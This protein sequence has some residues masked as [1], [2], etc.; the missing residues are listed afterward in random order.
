MA[1]NVQPGEYS[2]EVSTSH[3]AMA[4]K[5][6][7]KRI[8]IGRVAALHKDY[9]SKTTFRGQH[10]AA[11]SLTQRQ[12]HPTFKVLASSHSFILEM[13]SII[14]AL[15]LSG[16]T[17]A[18]SESSSVW[19]GYGIY[20]PSTTLATATSLSTWSSQSFFSTATTSPPASSTLQT[21]VASTSSAAAGSAGAVSL[22]SYIVQY[23]SS[24]SDSDIGSAKV[25]LRSLVDSSARAAGAD[26]QNPS[27]VTH[28]FNNIIQGFSGK[29]SSHVVEQLKGHPAFQ[30][31]EKDPVVNI[32]VPFNK[33][34][35][36][37]RA[38]SF[39]ATSVHFSSDASASFSALPDSAEISSTFTF[40]GMSYLGCI[41]NDVANNQNAFRFYVG[42]G[43][44][45]PVTFENCI[46]EC[47]ARGYQ[48]AGAGDRCYCD[49][50]LLRM[51]SSDQCDTRCA[52]NPTELC[53]NS[54]AARLFGPSGG[55]TSAP[56]AAP[57]SMQPTATSSQAPAK[58]SSGSGSG[59]SAISWNG[60]SWGVVRI[61]GTQFSSSDYG[62]T[63]ASIVAHVETCAK[64][65]A[66][67][68]VYVLDTGVLTTHEDFG[69]RASWGANFADNTDADLNG[70]GTHVASGAIGYAA[71]MGKK[72]NVIAVKILGAD[73]SG[74]G[75]SVLQG[76]EWVLQQQTSNPKPCI[77]NMSLGTSGVSS[78]INQAVEN[79]VAA[80]VTV[81]VAAG[82]EAGDACQ[83]SPASASG[84]IT[85]GA[86]GNTAS[87][88]FN[89]DEIAQYSNFGS[90]VDVF[91]PGTLLRAAIN[92]GN[93]DYGEM[94]G[95]SMASPKTA[96][97]AAYLLGQ[98]P[99][100]NPS[101]L[102]AKMQSLAAQNAVTGNINGSPNLLVQIPAGSISQ[103]CGEWT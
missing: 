20:S 50:S 2:A 21:I 27:A 94:S 87:G 44:V 7:A 66:V 32:S 31:I 88:A 3:E 24:L 64:D 17:L 47:K 84:A 8:K 98:N 102:L 29:F 5:P 42:L 82:N 56:N 11:H 25:Y 33:G 63:D 58:T 69:G 83:T 6:L 97:V 38:E 36:A 101:Q 91:A 90:C 78:A 68:I 76:M 43:T 96:G 37:R 40:D 55:A 28:E 80:G 62:S 10:I 85:V 103:V 73:G 16:V 60:Q 74:S 75:T 14:S 41:L 95:T 13:L 71:G 81:V 49:N 67:V 9:I 65:P 1:T 70:H 46:T 57:T 92:T 48:Y 99:G 77:V 54:Q 35:H 51:T 15:T 53:G 89:H 22:Q 30:S 39:N 59:E 34:P 12:C 72:S 100:A 19:T 79:L 45:L 93:S 26:Q 52:G 86:I 18:S 4:Q 23:K 61:Q